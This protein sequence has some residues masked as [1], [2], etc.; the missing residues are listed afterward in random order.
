MPRHA[1]RLVIRLTLTNHR[2]I[3][4]RRTYHPCTARRTA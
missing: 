2:T 4:S 1:V 3:V